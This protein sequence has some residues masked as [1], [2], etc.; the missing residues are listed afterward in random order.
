MAPEREPEARSTTEG[1]PLETNAGAG[2][3][4]A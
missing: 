1:G 3:A 4:K 2:P